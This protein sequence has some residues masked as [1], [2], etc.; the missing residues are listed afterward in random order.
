MAMWEL[1]S[2]SPESPA[3]GQLVNMQRAREGLHNA[4]RDRDGGKEDYVGET[5]SSRHG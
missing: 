2:Q 1:D 5:G 3:N 4:A